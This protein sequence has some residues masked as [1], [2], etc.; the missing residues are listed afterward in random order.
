KS[1]AF[2]SQPLGNNA[3]NFSKLSVMFSIPES[4]ADLQRFVKLCAY[5]SDT[6]KIN[7]SNSSGDDTGGGARDQTGGTTNAGTSGTENPS[8]SIVKEEWRFA[9]RN[10]TAIESDYQREL[11]VPYPQ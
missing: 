6:T 10:K 11:G 7:A 8:D 5:D 9:V 1:F 2:A 4:I 3:N